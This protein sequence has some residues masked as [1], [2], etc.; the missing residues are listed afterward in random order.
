MRLESIELKGFK[1]F[2]N[3]TIIPF[4]KQ[5]TAIVGPNGSGKSNISDAIRWVLGEQSVK[6]LR[7]SKMNDVIF[8]G[9]GG[10]NSMN[11]AEVNLNFSNED[12]AL[13]LDYEKVVISRRIYRDGENE[14]KING[15][16]VRL[17]DVRELFL[18]TG[19]GKEG[20]SLIGQGR[21]DEIIS[22]SNLQ[23]RA[24][25]EEAS[26][27]SKHKYRRDEAS[28]K[29]T[30]VTDD[31]EIIE[32]EWEYKSK[33]LEKLA[34][35]AKNYEK[36]QGLST[37]LDKKAYGYVREKS[38]NLL[39]SKEQLITEIKNLSDDI[40]K[41]TNSLEN[42]KADLNPFNEHF[43]SLSSEKENIESKLSKNKKLIENN[44]NKIELNEKELTYNKKDLAR[45]T[46]NLSLNE[47]KYETFNERLAADE[48]NLKNKKIDLN[49]SKG[50]IE[51]LNLEIKS[52]K[53]KNTKLG[54]DIRTI[55]K[56]SEK[57]AGQIYDLEINAKTNELLKERRSKE[58]SE[59]QEKIKNLD[60]EIEN[61]NK[62]IDQLSVK[63]IKDLEASD[64]LSK[65]LENIQ[66]DLSKADKEISSY[67]KK[68]NNININLKTA[69]NE[70][71]FNKNLVESNEGYFYSVQNFLNKTKAN[72]LDHLYED[73]L[74]NLINVKNGYE[75]IIDNLM[76]QAVQNIVTR[77]KDD[78]KELINFVNK[79]N[80]GRITFLPVD[81]IKSYEKSRPNE[82]EV[83]DMANELL[84]FDPKY[85]GIINHF[86]GST[87]VVKNIDDA[88]N[89]SKKIKGYRII[90]LD[91]DVINSWGSM[92]AGSNKNKKTNTN[93]LNRNKKI[94]QTKEKINFLKS[95]NDKAKEKL[96]EIISSKNALAN[97][98]KKYQ[99]DFEGLKKLIND[100]N[101]EIANLSYKLQ[102]LQGQK[103]DLSKSL[104]IVEK[105]A[106]DL[107]LGELKST[108]NKYEIL[109][110]DNN[111]KL[112]TNEVS[113][114]GLEND[115]NKNENKVELLNRDI[116]MIENAIA[117]FKAEL[118]NLSESKKIESKLKS[119]T[120]KIISD[121]ESSNV[122]LAN[123]I[124]EFT[125]EV[126]DLETK[127]SDKNNI[128]N[129]SQEENAKLIEKSKDLEESLNKI[130][131][132]KVELSYKLEGVVKDYDN[133]LDEIKPFLSKEMDE[134]EETFKD[135]KIEKVSKTDLI[136]LQRKINNIGYFTAD[137]LNNYK[138]TKEEFAFIDSQVKD[139]KESKNN[140]EKLIKALESEMKDEFK[141]NF[142]IINNKFSEIFKVL[143]M[144]GDARLKLDNDDELLAGVEIVARP[145]S[146][147]LKSI[148]LLSGGEKALTAVALLFS[149]FETNPAPFAILDEIDAALDETNI[150]RYIEY[151]KSLSVHS[152]FI[153]ITHR[154][155]TMQL[156]EKIHGV[157]I[158]DVGISKVYSIDFDKN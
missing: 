105:E 39:N 11:L 87:V 34:N 141:K 113:I 90:T 28:K 46:E 4:E 153:M 70:Y 93:L 146:K 91:L 15:K 56:E 142:D 54:L 3:K 26:G 64:K 73:T 83:I 140:I 84:D 145:P 129:K 35:E 133:L 33:D 13:A 51:N 1:S 104:E 78:S 42:I 17:K 10:K 77:T 110:E 82:S 9:A 25:F 20:Y 69:I 134:L 65:S 101:N 107:D 75:E 94:D 144:G 45:I 55:K 53:E 120:E 76:G 103:K 81:S 131:I 97:K 31:L 157:T 102:N 43:K 132:K 38:T 122:K 22:S 156:A 151:L 7:G 16:K 32:R 123:Q 158:G 138:E 57:I 114:K 127:L 5:I 135:L 99:T 147:S 68:L 155:T 23:R 124:K 61:V 47:K 67:Q 18:D 8:Q 143:F 6:S 92:V 85:A 71:K 116:N 37:E 112:R 126:V 24:L 14:Y 98:E 111:K 118:A 59:N 52:L 40:N 66:A 41:K 2:A 21:I 117:G 121:T 109:L 119:E 86:L 50:N 27:I 96:D 149:I 63:K 152:Q 115:L 89:L 62:N 95:E 128:L 29:L 139:L 100:T 72:K 108:K 88:T 148:S 44:R 125:A 80:I 136:N 150:K 74:A 48:E 12:H 19:I 58:L 49:E 60:L 36:W 130:N 154:Q 30:K 137:S 79:N 106:S